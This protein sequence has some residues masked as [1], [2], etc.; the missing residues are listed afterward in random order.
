MESVS[1]SEC[2]LP[3][4]N[5]EPE[6]M[7]TDLNCMPFEILDNFVDE[8]LDVVGKKSNQAFDCRTKETCRD[9]YFTTLNRTEL[10]KYMAVIIM[11]GINK[12]PDASLH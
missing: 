8:F 9:R 1:P 10:K 2:P 12:L 7:L 11:M 5:S 6:F 3:E 4:W